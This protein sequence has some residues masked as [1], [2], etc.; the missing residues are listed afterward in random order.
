MQLMLDNLPPD[1]SPETLLA[2]LT[3]LGIPAPVELSIAP[4]LRSRPSAALSLDLDYADM[5]AVVKLLDGR[6]W[7]GHV[8]HASHATLFR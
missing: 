4:G 3:E 1:V 6:A 7:M 5:E 8:L 2:L